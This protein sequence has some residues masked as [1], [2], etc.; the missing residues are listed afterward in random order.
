MY[1]FIPFMSSSLPCGLLGSVL[2]LFFLIQGFGDISAF[3]LLISSFC[4]LQSENILNM[5]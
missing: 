4:P 5:M 3:L 1:S 2:L